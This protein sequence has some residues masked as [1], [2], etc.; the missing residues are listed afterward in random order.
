MTLS[1][2][3]S[4]ICW[5]N[6]I[7]GV[8]TPVVCLNGF[9]RT[10]NSNNTTK[11]VKIAI[12]RKNCRAYLFWKV[13]FLED[14]DLFLTILIRKSFR[15]FSVCIK[16]SFLFTFTSVGFNLVVK[17]NL[18]LILQTFFI[19]IL[20]IFSRKRCNLKLARILQKFELFRKI[21]L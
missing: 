14:G 6:W 16:F 20:C 12:I 17:M 4:G 11:A 7:S 10:V 9:I 5:I 18:M 3:G 2:L 21:N 1:E 19:V 15:S 13:A 8:H